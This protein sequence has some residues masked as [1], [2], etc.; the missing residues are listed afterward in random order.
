[1]ARYFAPS[2][3]YSRHAA[4]VSRRPPPRLYTGRDQGVTLRERRAL[5]RMHEKLRMGGV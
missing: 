3:R 2:P 1:M 4:V 5:I